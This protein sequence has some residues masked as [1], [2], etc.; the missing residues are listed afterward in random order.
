MPFSAQMAA[1]RACISGVGST[2]LG[3]VTAG[4]GWEALRSMFS[5][6]LRV[7]MRQHLPFAGPRQSHP[8]TPER[9]PR[10]RRA[11]ECGREIT[12]EFLEADAANPERGRFRIRVIRGH[13]DFEFP[14][15]Q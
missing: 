4:A 14:K 10:P 15:D 8:P 6:P 11:I 5:N 7:M 1:R 9:Q 13:K 3:S 12:L 2:C